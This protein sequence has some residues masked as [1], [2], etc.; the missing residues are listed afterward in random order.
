[1]S[2]G[3]SAEKATGGLRARLDASLP[4]L[5]LMGISCWMAW[6]SVAFSGAFWLH[7]AGTSVRVESLIVVHLVSCLVALL[8]AAAFASRVRG[9]V[10]RPAFVLGS[11]F[12]STLGTLLIVITCEAIFPSQPLF[13]LGC[14]LSGVGTTGLFLRFAP[15]AGSLPPRRSFTALA[16]CSLAASLMFL[17]MANMSDEV[18]SGFFVALPLAG[19]LLMCVRGE[20]VP[21]ELRVLGDAPKGECGLR[22]LALFLASVALCSAALELMK[23]TV[24]VG[25]TPESSTFY[26]THSELILTALFAAVVIALHLSLI[27]I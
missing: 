25:T 17:C 12:A 13:V 11:G 18:A 9:F 2:M 20:S 14:V 19:S 6:N 10:T 24:L 1:M 22:G 15:M 23:A 7:D 21:A 26:R 3:E 8:L 5:A 16:E 27:H 4:L